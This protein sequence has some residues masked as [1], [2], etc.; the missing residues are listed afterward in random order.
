M[1]NPKLVPFSVLAGEWNTVGTHPLLPGIT[2]HGHVSIEW[3]EDG[4]FLRM[5][6]TVEQPDVPNGVFIF[7]SDDTTEVV[8]MI[9]FDVRGVSRIY[10]TSLAGNIWKTWRNVPGFSQ[11][12]TGTLTDHNNTIRVVG[13]LSRD[14]STWARD[15]EQ[16]YTRVR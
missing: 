5:R 6:S 12:S 15:L 7:G 14:D 1:L 4:A 8:S 11:R 9:Y 13:E 16:T 10:E 2:L 3:I